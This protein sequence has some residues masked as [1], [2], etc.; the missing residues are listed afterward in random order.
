MYSEDS[1][2]LS[3]EQRLQQFGGL[4]QKCVFETTSKTTQPTEAGK[5]KKPIA[6]GQCPDDK[7]LISFKHCRRA[8]PEATALT[9]ITRARTDEG[10]RRQ[11][12]RQS[13]GQKIGIHEVHEQYT[14]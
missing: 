1:F 7:S 8:V 3:K 14:R 2:N 10:R 4:T 12:I 9:N 5:R 6:S 11:P 13:S